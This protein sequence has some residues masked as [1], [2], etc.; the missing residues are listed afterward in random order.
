MA[1][2]TRQTDRRPAA[3]RTRRVASKPAASARAKDAADPNKGASFPIVGIGASAGGLEAFTQLIHH[4]PLDIGMG[5][6]LVQHLDPTHESALTQILARATSLPVS[7]ITDRQPVEPNHVYVI[8]RDTSLH[9]VD[10][11]LKLEPRPKIRGPH[12][13]I[14]A[15]FES[16]AEDQGNRAIG[17][18][19]SG[20]ASDGTQGLEAI[21]AEGG[22]TFAQDDSAKYDSMPRSAVAAGCVDLVLSPADIARELARIAKHPYVIDPLEFPAPSDDEPGADDRAGAPGRADDEMPPPAGGKG[23][24]GNKTKRSHAGAR[25]KTADET[26]QD[27]Y[28]KILVLLRN[29]SGVDFTLYKSTTIKRRITRRLLL[30]K[31]NTL[32]DY[33]GFLS[34][35]AAELN[36][37]YSDVLISVTSFFRN[38][39]MFDELRRAV[40]P[41]LLK[42]RG[43][44]PLRCWVLGCS[45]GEEAYSIAMAFVETAEKAPRAR[46]LQIFATDLNETLLDKAR[47][48]LYAKSLEQ[49]IAPERLRRFFVEEEGG[50]RISKPLREM[51]VF[52]RHN[53]ISDPPFS[54]M[55]LISCRNVL[56]YLE[57]GLQKKVLPTFH[58]ALKPGGFLILGA[59]ESIGGFTDLFEPVDKKHKIFS[60]KTASTLA[61]HLPVARARGAHLPGLPMHPP[62]RPEP[63]EGSRNESDALREADR[64]TV[65]QFAPPGVLINADLHVMQFRG[66]TGTYLEPPP[67]KASFDILKMAREG[68]MLPLRSVINQARK[69]NKTARKENV[70]FMHDGKTR[71]VDLEVIPLK[72]LRE[73]CF[74]ILFE[75]PKKT[76]RADKIKPAAPPVSKK[77]ERSRI[78]D[79]ETEIAETREYLQSLQEQHEA[80]IEELQAANEEVQSANEELQSVN[81]ELETSKEELESANEELTTVNE[82]MQNRNLE[83]NRLIN[84]LG[85]LQASTRLAIM[86]LGRDLTIRRFS[87]QA[88]K[89][90]DL[91]ATDIGRPIGHIRH[92]LVRAPSLPPN[93][94]NGGSDEDLP[95]DLESTFAGVIADVQEQECEVRDRAGRW[96]L[97]RVRPYMT[98]D[99][100]VDGA[101]LVL[102]DI[103]ALKRGEQAIAEARDYAESI[104]ATLREPLLVLDKNLRIESANRAFFRAFRVEPRE[105]LGKFIYDLGNRQWDIP[106]LRELLGEILHGNTTIE[107]FP[108]EH[109]FEPLGRRIML[110]NACRVADTRRKSDRILVAIEDITERSEAEQKLRENHA[111]LLAYTEELGRFNQAAV[112]REL[113]MIELKKEVNVLSMRLGQPAPYSLEFERGDA[114]GGQTDTNQEKEESATK[115]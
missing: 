20:T 91:L 42:Q 12:R 69:T 71:A 65:T 54:R 111:Q 104:V 82:E 97:M 13:P 32:A 49:D 101:V 108:V 61:L 4:L 96:F 43:D 8:P 50:Y 77:Q 2:K 11:V 102:V 106:R 60:R 18:V 95:V 47:K 103:D 17:I 40:L 35:N 92:G 85:N 33:A 88:Q 23:A 67:G 52:A 113:R 31:Q 74:L 105:T 64:I 59:S 15:F 62:Q 37:L 87:P 90:F 110:L 78:A 48:G 28:K 45:T 22:I 70:R 1:S 44:D 56:I 112:G 68:L 39:E 79:L 89:Q 55:D 99:N 38:P 53:L 46:N 5:F 41:A 29:H 10:G 63:P 93:G 75:E 98:L 51:V 72:N 94:Q 9:I 16:L 76:R 34:G 83:L 109:H 14:D 81:E 73:H 25:R 19:L 84:D 3:R 115:S 80:A 26:A 6:I 36:A 21:K 24:R 66:P 7:E 30:S 114:D 86:L 100:K 107:D 58:Y 27:A 57:P